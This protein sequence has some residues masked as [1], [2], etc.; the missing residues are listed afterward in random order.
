MAVCESNHMTTFTAI[1]YDPFS[2]D[3]A[4]IEVI[5]NIPS[6]FESFDWIESFMNSFTFY[7]LT[8]VTGLFLLLLIG[9]KIKDKRDE[10]SD[11]YNA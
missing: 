8:I 4:P 7:Y 9:L 2:T 5:V 6:L 1:W 11:I 10:H 3:R